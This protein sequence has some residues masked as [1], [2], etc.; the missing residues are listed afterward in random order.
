MAETYDGGTPQRLSGAARVIEDVF[1][2]NALIGLA[3]AMLLLISGYPTWAGMHD[4]ILG[5]SG[6]T[7]GQGRA[8]PGGFNVS[9]DSL[10]VMVVITLTFLMWLALRE[11]VGAG[12]TWKERLITIPLYV[13]LALWSIGFG[14]GFWWS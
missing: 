10:V 3:S 14:Y 4:F 1:G 6:A 8:T 11:S 7:G 12:R 5:V 9:H 2:R 13:F